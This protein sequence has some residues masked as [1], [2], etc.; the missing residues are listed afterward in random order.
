MFRQRGSTDG[1]GASATD[2]PPFGSAELAVDTLVGDVVIPQLGHVVAVEVT[3]MFETVW[4]THVTVPLVIVT[5]HVVR[6]VRVVTVVRSMVGTLTP[7]EDVVFGVRTGVGD[8]HGPPHSVVLEVV[9]KTVVA[10]HEPW[11]PVIA[12]SPH[13]V[14]VDEVTV[15][16]V[17]IVVRVEVA[18]V[19]KGVVIPPVVL[20]KTQEPWSAMDP[21]SVQ[22]LLEKVVV[23]VLV[24]DV[25]VSA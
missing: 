25:V 9:V 12:P 22:K 4:V 3:V 18:P 11:L 8:S 14:P 13:E 24:G 17:A 20:G 6:E 19:V 1:Y 5:G 10:G 2:P 7:I 15:A 21:L 16:I 23:S